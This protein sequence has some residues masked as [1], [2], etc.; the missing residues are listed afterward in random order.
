MKKPKDSA[1][2]PARP[3]V[4][5]FSD[6]KAYVE[7]WIRSSPGG[8]R[9]IRTQLAERMRCHLTYVSQVLSGP[10]HF[11]LEQ[12]LALNSLFDHGEDE[13]EF[14]I[15]L[16]EHARAGTPELQRYFQRKIQ[17]ILD[18]RL[19]LKNRFQD[20]KTLNATD[21]AIYYSDWIYCAVHMSVL[22]SSLRSP[23]ALAR[24]L[25]TSLAKTRRA[26]EFLETVGLVQKAEGGFQ[27]TETRIHL[28]SDSPLI[29]KH[30]SN[31]RL[32]AIR[33]LDRESMS[34]L[35]YS[36]VI[37]ISRENLPKVRELLVKAIEQIRAIVRDSKDEEI[38]CYAL[39]LFGLAAGSTE[40]ELIT[41]H[42][43]MH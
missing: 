35:H 11:S 10:G 43:K 12:G 36:S 28:A 19:I 32:Q 38:Y 18:Q 15:L 7:A 40:A 27:G 22:V 25:G 41:P 33:S 23:R 8:G 20:K 17:K 13:S 16:L 31:W 21:Q 9:G 1:V 4:Y 14:F 37:G 26:L 5:E 42:Q 34:E 39:D 29:A 6:Y 3:I 24:Y 30:H 2:P